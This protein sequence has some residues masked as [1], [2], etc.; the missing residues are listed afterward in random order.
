MKKIS[1]TPYADINVGDTATYSKILTREDTR[2]F[3][4]TSGDFNPVH[5]DEDYAKD[6]QFGQCIGHGMWSGAIISAAIASTLPGPGSVY[7]SQSLKFQKPVFIGDTLTVTLKV[8]DKKDRLKL[9]S[10]DC[11]VT[12]QDNNKVCTGEAQVIA[13]DTHLSVDFPG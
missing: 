9:V 8:T 12:N 6:T 3:A 7:R 1:N 11:E 5:L 13:Q 10:I 4:E 2:L